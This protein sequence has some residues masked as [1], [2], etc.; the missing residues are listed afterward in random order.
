MQHA[1]AAENLLPFLKPG[2]R[3]LDVGSG[4]GYLCAVLYRI[5]QDE[6]DQRSEESK[7]V[8]IDHIPELVEWSVGNL[9]QDGLGDAVEHGRIKMVAGD[10]RKGECCSMH[11]AQPLNGGG[12]CGFNVGVAGVPEEGPFDVIHVGAA[13]PALPAALVE[14]LACPG[15]M[16]IPVGTYAQQIMQVDKDEHGR[17]TEIPLL[18]VMVRHHSSFAFS[19]SCLS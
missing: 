2:A 10:G 14:Q 1:H 19:A 13:A 15:R 18:D 16:F 12:T 11:G 7:V 4:S 6:A 5:L 17:V 3:V 8:G 9:R